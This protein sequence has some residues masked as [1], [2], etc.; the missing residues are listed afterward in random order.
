MV[1]QHTILTDWCASCVPILRSTRQESTIPDQRSSGGKSADVIVQYAE[2]HD[3]V[4]FFIT[5]QNGFFQHI[6][7]DDWI[8][9]HPR[10]GYIREDFGVTPKMSTYLIGFIVSNLVNTNVSRPQDTPKL[11]EINFWARKEVADMTGF[12]YRMTTAILP[13]L[14]EY[15]GVR[16]TMPKIDM[17]AVPDFGF[18]AMENWGL[19]TFR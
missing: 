1:G 15:F 13:Y 17:V 14:E 9:R 18:N 10:P 6:V 3:F 4:S 19:I 7:L 12:S 5:K 16:F 2:H 11:P 8:H